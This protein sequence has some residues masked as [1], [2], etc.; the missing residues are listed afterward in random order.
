MGYTGNTRQLETFIDIQLTRGSVEEINHMLG[1][2]IQTLINII[3][4]RS[5]GI[6]CQ[7]VYTILE[8][9]IAGWG[10]QFM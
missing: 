4:E 5:I 3:L 8:V 9:N 10:G 1:V 7:S 2:S 6:K